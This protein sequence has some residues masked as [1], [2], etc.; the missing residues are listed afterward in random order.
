MHRITDGTTDEAFAEQCFLWE[1]GASVGATFALL[2]VKIF[3]MHKN[4]YNTLKE[5]KKR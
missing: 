5:R 1:R 4:F 3:Y 2:T